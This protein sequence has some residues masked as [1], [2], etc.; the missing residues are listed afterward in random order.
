MTRALGAVWT[1]SRLLR[2]AAAAATDFYACCISRLLLFGCSQVSSSTCKS[3][4][5]LER[6]S[7]KLKS[8]VRNLIEA[9]FLAARSTV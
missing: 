1:A 4:N 2:F 9:F 8:I 7:S 3:I 6:W 5:S